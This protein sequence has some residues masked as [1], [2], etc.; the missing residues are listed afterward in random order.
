VLYFV[1]NDLFELLSARLVIFGGMA[2]PVVTWH[3]FVQEFA[4][5]D[6]HVHIVRLPGRFDRLE[7]EADCDI[8]SLTFGVCQ[9]VIDCY[10]TLNLFIFLGFLF[11][12]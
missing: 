12:K 10:I 4:V 6:I 2:H 1:T 8:M 11:I 7:H 3:K 5:H 9:V